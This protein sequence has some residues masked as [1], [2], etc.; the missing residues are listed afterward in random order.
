MGIGVVRVLDLR[1]ELAPSIIG[2]RITFLQFVAI[3]ASLAV[4]LSAD[5]QL[6]LDL[7]DSSMAALRAVGPSILHSL[8]L[9][10][11]VGTVITLIEYGRRQT[12]GFEDGSL[13]KE[14][15]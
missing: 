5:M 1:F 11:A 10:T 8:Y 13:L 2:K 12:R 7:S 15:S 14:S 4:A 6:L 3:L 9:L